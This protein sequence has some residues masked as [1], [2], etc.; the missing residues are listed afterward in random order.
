MGKTTG[1]TW[2]DATWNPWRG[3]KKVSPGCANCYM[4]RDAKRYGHD[5]EIIV[6]S[7]TTFSDPVKWSKSGKVA[8]GSKIFVCSWSDF[9]IEQADEWRNEAW[10]IIRDAPY[11]FQLCT[12]RPERIY[13]CLPHDWGVGYRNVWLGVTGENQTQFDRR[14]EILSTIPA[15]T[16]WVSIEPMLERMTMNISQAAALDWVVIGG[17]SGSNA[18]PFDPKWIDEFL[19]HRVSSDVALFVKQMGS[20]PVGLD[21]KHPHGADP[22]E[23]VSMYRVQEF[24]NKNL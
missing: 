12:K 1:I 13:K 22:Q 19:V 24:P 6:R 2:T 18:R 5:P 4:Y 16:Y 23:W 20:N 17:E 14:L 15:F 11:V 21:L 10:Q 7:K 8:R 3:C 9:F